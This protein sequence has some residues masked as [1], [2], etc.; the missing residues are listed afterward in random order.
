VGANLVYGLLDSSTNQIISCRTPEEKT[1]FCSEIIAYYEKKVR[2]P[3]FLRI[4]FKYFQNLDIVFII[5]YD[6]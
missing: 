3:F 5:V 1:K 4:F 2:I 6:S